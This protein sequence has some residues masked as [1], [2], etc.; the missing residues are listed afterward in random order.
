MKRSATRGDQGRWDLAWG[1]I[2]TLGL[3]LP[4]LWTAMTSRGPGIEK[5]VQWM[6]S[7][8]ANLAGFS[9]RKGALVAGADADVVV[10][11][12]AAEWTVAPDH[13][14]FRHKLSPYLGAQL[15]GRVLET[16][17]R[18]EPVLNADGFAAPR[19]KELIR[20]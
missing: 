11:D 8:P 4:V 10:F 17:L 3:A 5:L 7:A 9:R 14:H 15:R 13:L 12:P 19:G 6:G 20:E 18:G 1:G 2:A 16:W